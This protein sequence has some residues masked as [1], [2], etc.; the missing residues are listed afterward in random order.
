MKTGD[1]KVTICTARFETPIG[2]LTVGAIDEGICFVEFSD[3]ES[4]APGLTSVGLSNATMLEGSNQHLLEVGGQLKEYFKGRRREFNVSLS[5]TGTS[6]QEKV[7]KS[8]LD[9]PYG[10]TR[11]YKDQST[12]L[13]M[14]KAIRAIAHANGM[15]PIAIL[16]PCHRVIGEDGSLTGYA[17]GLW[18]KQWLLE[19]E[20]A[21]EP[22]L[23]SSKNILLPAEASG[24]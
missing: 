23:F 20:G 13:G 4:H 21:R 16:I 9:I 24:A 5:Y 14:P 6:F 8:L 7:W 2:Q 18:R 12:A 1:Q 10:K 19:H 22:T 3:S 15:N 11:S 17:G